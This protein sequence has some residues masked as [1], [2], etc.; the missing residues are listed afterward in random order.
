MRGAIA[1][2]LSTTM[3]EP[4]RTPTSLINPHFQPSMR[5]PFAS[6]PILDQLIETIDVTP[7]EWQKFLQ[8]YCGDKPYQAWL[9]QQGV[10]PHDFE[11]WARRELAIRKF[12]HRQWGR[13]VTSYFLDRK[14]QL[15]RVIYSLICVKDQGLAQE[16]YFR[17]VEGEATFED[18]ARVYSQGAEA[19]RGGR[20]G[21]VELGQLHPQ[22][23]RLFYGARP[24]QLWGPM[25]LKPWIVVARL[26][27]TIPV[28]FDDAM[29]QVL[30]NELLEQW[31]KEQVSHKRR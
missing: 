15:D 31:L 5:A 22:L 4:R 3:K 26:D 16:L 25:T 6:Q 29:R 2:S 7:E 21:P 28:Q 27:E 24:G 18:M 19:S 8:Q 12:Q 9:Q 1:G 23:S 17:L 14:R 20:V 13:T 10:T 11:T 30:L